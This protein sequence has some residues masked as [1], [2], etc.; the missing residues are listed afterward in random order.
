VKFSFAPTALLLGNFVI[1][2]SIMGPTGM[3]NELSSGLG[4]SIRDTGLLITFGAAALFICSPLSAWL[5]GRFDRRKFLGGLIVLLAL[6][7]A[8]SAFAPDYATLMAIRLVMM[9]VAAPFTPQA[10][11]TVSLI[12]PVEKRGSTIAYVF[13]GWSLAAAAGLPMVTIIASHA[14]WR[15]AYLCIAALSCISFLLLIWQLPSRVSGVAVDLKTWV[16]LGRNPLVVM[17]L[18]ITILQM[19]GQFIL[20]T[21]MAPLLTRLAQAT[22][23]AI[24]VVFALYGI[25][26]FIGNVMATQL[27][28]RWG[29]YRTS[30]VFVVV[31]L[32]GIA[33]WAVGAGTL[34]VMAVGV[35][36][37]GIG[38]ASTNSMQQ[39]RLVGAAPPFA[40]ASVSLNTS[41]LYVGQAIGS[42][43]GGVLF[44]RDML[45]ALGYVG[46]AF[47][48]AALLA[49]LMT[50]RFETAD[51]AKENA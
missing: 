48:V 47:V 30:L 51:V 42:A 27:V 50:R 24:A 16:S 34:A 32:A 22:P 20:L 25:F 11:G 12:V 35:S 8:A 26:G 40:G 3:L 14:G 33:I 31:L 45:Y 4:V 36:V 17:L 19:S 18:L 23:G 13:L 15:T 46:V 28:D 10:A 9:A 43:I 2:T 41:V 21:F 5:T 1:G 29:G 7:N 44:A 6:C 49:V 37:W 39:V 38:F